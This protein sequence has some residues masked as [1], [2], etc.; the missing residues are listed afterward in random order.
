MEIWAEV[1]RRILTREI[2][3]RQACR[4]YQ[5]NWR[6]VKKILAHVEPQPKHT[7]PRAKPTLDPV[8]H[9]IH[10][11]LDAD[12]DAPPRQRHTDARIHQ[13]LCD[14]HGYTGCVRG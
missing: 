10:A 12:R 7:A 6:T 5:L 4:E 2:S 14:E 8:L 3:M 11:I 1:R 13:R 9:L